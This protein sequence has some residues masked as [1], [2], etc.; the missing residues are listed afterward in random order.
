MRYAI[1]NET[2]EGWQHERVCRFVAGLGYRGLEIAPFTLAPRITD[3]SPERRRT[4]RKQAEDHGLAIIGLHIGFQSFINLGVFSWTMIGYTPF[5]LTA[6]EWTLF[7]RIASEQLDTVWTAADLW[8]RNR[9]ADGDKRTLDQLRVAALVQWAQS[10]LHHGDPTYCDQW[11]TPGS[12]GPVDTGSGDEGG[13]D[14]DD[15]GDGGTYPAPA[16][17]GRRVLLVQYGRDRVQ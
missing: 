13:P 1:C 3:V 8:A 6:S 11:C 12:H 2:F 15:S 9:K 17:V 14:D 16:V 4:L 7:A 10:Y 5:L